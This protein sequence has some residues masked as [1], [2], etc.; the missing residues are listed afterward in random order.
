MGMIRNIQQTVQDRDVIKQASDIVVY[1]DGTNYLVNPYLSDD[2][3][4]V[5]LNDFL[6]NWQSTNGVEQS[7][8]SGS[9]T[10]SVP[11]QHTHLFQAPGGNN[12]LKTMAEIRVYAKGYFFSNNAN[13][14]YH[15]IFR[16]YIS[17]ISYNITQAMTTISLSCQGS[18]G[19]LALM[20]IDSKPD[21]I[22]SSPL[23]A[24]PTVGTTWNLNPYDSMAYQFLYPSM[25]D[26]FSVESVQQARMDKTNVYYKAVTSGYM[27]KWQALLFDIARDVRIFGTP[28]VHDVIKGI[29]NHIKID[30]N[31]GIKSVLDLIAQQYDKY[32]IGTESTQRTKKQEYIKTIRAYMPE[33]T[34]GDIKLVGGRYASRLERFRYFAQL[35]GYECYQD[36]DGSIIAKIPLYNLDVTEIDPVSYTNDPDPDSESDIDPS[37]DYLR[38]ENNPFVVSLSEIIS[39]NE[40]ENEAG[41]RFTRLSGRGALSTSWQ[42]QSDPQYMA[43]AEDIDL[44]KL[45]QFGLRTEP[46]LTAGFFQNTDSKAI[47]AYVASELAKAN[48]GF[49]TYSLTIPLRPEIRVGF[50]MYLPHRDMYGYI[51]TVSM[52]WSRG[53]SATTTITLDSLRRRV[54]IPVD[55]TVPGDP[56]L[57]EDETTQIIRLMEPQNNLVNTWTL[58]PTGS[59][60][61][62]SKIPTLLRRSNLIPEVTSLPT[63]DGLVFEQQKLLVKARS[64]GTDYGINTDEKN[65]CWRIQQDT[66]QLFD[67]PRQIDAD[68]YADL[69]TS[70]P[71]TDNKGYE[72][73]GPFPWGRWKCLKVA[74]TAFV[75]GDSI[76]PNKASPTSAIKPATSNSTAQVSNAAAFLFTGDS[77]A[78]S[79][80]AITPLINDLAAQAAVVTN[81]KVFELTYDN[82]SPGSQAI[83]PKPADAPDPD[84]AVNSRTKTSL[85]G[86]PK[87]K[88]S[89]DYILDSIKKI[90]NFVKSKV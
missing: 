69:R 84:D 70:R 73:V 6:T 39:E 67:H 1:I 7:I 77:A 50:P 89:T 47:Y 58:P 28:N 31:S 42:I 3:V 5:P 19:L 65:H 54:L 86:K 17:S 87:Y 90:G 52:N 27:A 62:D 49:R 38:P 12:I 26:A 79:Q 57:G 88:P 59:D 45:T 33:A 53:S 16:G 51:Q 15:Q 25:I 29:Q 60:D 78:P 36:V 2:G 48:R 81:S 23:S 35:V 82:P 76:S 18:M 4:V 8:P 11:S 34:I 20:Q 72:L 30:D 80:E 40:A 63:P 21:V 44:N 56:D 55:Q 13:T 75:L 14:L 22:S 74:L 43:T 41:V 71:Y 24:Q 66:K 46:A 85:A 32:G 61:G 68:Y 64:V 83:P 37:L 10:L 9:L